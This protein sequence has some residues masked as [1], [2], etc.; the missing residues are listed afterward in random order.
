MQIQLWVERV[1][2]HDWV[3]R[4]GGPTDVESLASDEGEHGYEALGAR[5]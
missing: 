1:Y 5:G 2:L 4:W 3:A